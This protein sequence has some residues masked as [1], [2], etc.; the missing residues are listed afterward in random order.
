MET[1]IMES[2]KIGDRVRQL[3]DSAGLTQSDVAN[4]LHVDQS[5]IS[6]CEKNERQ[7]SAAVFEK[8]SSL[9]GCSSESLLNPAAPLDS[10]SLSFRSAS[11]QVSDYEAVS[12]INRIALNIKQMR[13][14]FERK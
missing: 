5:Y 13:G 14:L 9:L 6:K 11:L 10:L 1:K 4:Y 12:D 3:R 7:F 8:L 2:I